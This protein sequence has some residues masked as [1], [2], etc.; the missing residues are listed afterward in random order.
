[1]G[2]PRAS[3][4]ILQAGCSS[5][6]NGLPKDGRVAGN[7]HLP[8]PGGTATRFTLLPLTVS[9]CVSLPQILS[10]DGLHGLQRLIGGPLPAHVRTKF[11]EELVTTRRVHR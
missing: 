2:F 1:M 5:S 7:V 3:A 6:Y 10:E 4:A 11:L 8:S 9:R